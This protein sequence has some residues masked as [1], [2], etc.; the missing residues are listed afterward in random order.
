MTETTRPSWLPSIGDILFLVVLYLLLGILPNFIF[1]DGST[2][3]H[4]VTGHYI[5]ETGRVPATDLVSYTF[6]DKAWVAYEWLF[7]AFIAGLDKLGG[8]RL[9]SVACCSAI[10]TMFLLIYRDCRREGCH[11]A[12]TLVLCIMGVLVSAIHW[13]ARPHLVTWFGVY[14][15]ARFLH[16]HFNGEISA[17]KLWIILGL[18]MLIWVNCHPAFLMGFAILFIY[19]FCDAVVWLW[20]AAGE[21]KQE[22]TKRLK[23]LA[24]AFGITALASLIN[25]YGLK[26]YEY[27]FH[28]LKQTA[29]ISQTD[30]F[31]SPVFHGQL[32]PTCLE[33]LYF[34][35]ISGLVASGVRPALPA[36]M[37]T[38]AYAHLSLS[39]VRNMPLFV[40]VALPLIASLWGRNSRL[41]NLLGTASETPNKIVAFIKKSVSANAATFDE[42]ERICC[43][44]A[45]PI[46]TVILLSLSCLQDGKLFGK[47]FVTSKFKPDASPTTTLTAMKE[48]KLD[49]SKG[50]NYDNWGGLIRYKTGQRVFIDDRVDFYG[51]KFYLD[52]AD[53]ALV[54]PNWKQ[55]LDK[56][57]I[58]WILFPKNGVIVSKLREEKD[59]KLLAE[60]GGSVL[61]VRQTV[62]ASD[63]KPN[64]PTSSPADPT[65]LAP[66]PTS[67]H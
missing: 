35:L 3:W 66:T 39:G 23:G 43:R 61:F 59:W 28:Y 40:I 1:A 10:A 27:I 38:L 14:F 18:S 7:D 65:Q 6:P 42:V 17:R 15:F 11:Y 8:L 33:L 25:P 29:V 13:L 51:E 16:A 54:H 53:I 5:L 64:L 44:H 56:Y 24:A 9:V 30:E 62:P 12:L 34:A 45:V 21:K 36:L 63:S 31:A 60:D 41:E 37:T 32:Q 52:Y 19:L 58:E 20:L 49:P 55:L 48:H 46:I 50:F 2:G 47:E 57:K 26:L 4:L 22:V 67:T